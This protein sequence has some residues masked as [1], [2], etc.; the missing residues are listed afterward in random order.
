MLLQ[1]EIKI[2]TTLEIDQ[3]LKKEAIKKWKTTSLELILEGTRL[4]NIDSPKNR[5]K[6]N[7]FATRSNLGRKHKDIKEFT[8]LMFIDIDKCKDQIAVKELFIQ[9]D[10]TVAVWY[11]SSGKNV[12]ALIKIPICSSVDEYK[13]RYNAFIQLLEPYLKKLAKIDKITANPTQLAFESFDPCIF[14]NDAPM[15]FEL[16][17]PESKPRREI[18]INSIANPTNN[19]EQWCIKWLEKKMNNVVD[20]GYTQ[21][22]SISRTFGGYCSGGYINKDIA[23]DLLKNAVRTNNY[24]N[25][26]SSSGTLKTYLKGAEG[27]FI[28]G[29]SDPLTWDTLI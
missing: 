21:L 20:N 2:I 14:I 25:G 10:N 9:I 11:S 24:L 5:R 29:E 13:R 12:H 7:V 1:F 6:A 8:G 27:A 28:N 15:E 23:I 16:K 22:L 17:L 19:S 3:Y 18:Q 26:S 4:N